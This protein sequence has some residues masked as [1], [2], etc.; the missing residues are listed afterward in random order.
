MLKATNKYYRVLLCSAKTLKDMSVVNDNLEEGTISATIRYCQDNDLHKI[1]GSNLLWKLQELVGE[2]VIGEEENEK[3]KILLDEYIIPYM[4][5]RSVGELIPM[6]SY[7]IKNKGLVTTSD[8]HVQTASITEVEKMT[9]MYKG[10]A[11][12]YS[13][14]LKKFLCLNRTEYPELNCTCDGLENA[15]FGDSNNTTCS[16]Y[17]G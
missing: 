8:E 11:V 13:N 5:N 14:L 2:K 4:V 12:E 10:K 15:D 17:L 7:K 3:Y 6:I 16:I 9:E 1:I